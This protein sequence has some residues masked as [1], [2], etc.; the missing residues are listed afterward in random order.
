MPVQFDEHGSQFKNGFA[1]ASSTGGI[2]GFLVK[3]GFAGSEK[4]ANLL[5]VGIIVVCVVVT[6]VFLY[7]PSGAADAIPANNQSTAE[8]I[9]A[10]ESDQSISPAL[11]QK[12]LE[13]LKKQ[14]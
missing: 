14:Q 9:V 8:R 6:A 12:M 5:L 10:I 13:S 7:Y 2:I 11:K 3:K 4:Q 1:G